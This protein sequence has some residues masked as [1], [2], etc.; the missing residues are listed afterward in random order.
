MTQRNDQAEKKRVLWDGIE[1]PGLVSVADIPREKGTVDV[2]S[3]NRIRTIQ[4]GIITIPTIEMVYK[5]ERDSIALAFWESFYDNNEI[6]DG[7]II[8]TDGHGVEFSRRLIP[9][10]ECFGLTDPAYDAAAPDYAK[11]TVLVAP[12][13]FV[14]LGTA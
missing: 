1:I 6:H 7:V 3:F 9:A 2:P 13:D 12:W 10:C 5:L 11:F 8:R 4:N 14:S